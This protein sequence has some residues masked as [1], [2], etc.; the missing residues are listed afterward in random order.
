M[1]VPPIDWRE[2]FRRQERCAVEQHPEAL[3]HV[4]ILSN[5]ANSLELYCPT[6]DRPITRDRYP[7]VRGHAVTAEW[8]R[9]TLGIDASELPIHRRSIRFHICYLCGRTAQCEFHHVA[10]QA[11]YKEDANKYPVVP[12]CDDCHQGETKDFADRLE[13]YVTERIRRALGKRGAA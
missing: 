11:L 6:C 3:W 4:R 12:L 7:D 10:P 2:E 8:L 13:R 1:T 9:T 5:G